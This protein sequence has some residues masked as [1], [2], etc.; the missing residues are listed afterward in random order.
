MAGTYTTSWQSVSNGEQT[1]HNP[2][3]LVGDE[4]IEIT[5][6]QVQWEGIETTTE[7]TDY[8][9]STNNN[10]DTATATTSTSSGS[11][12]NSTSTDSKYASTSF[13]DIPSGATFDSHDLRYAVINGSSNEKTVSID[14]S[15]VSGTQQNTS[16][17][18]S[19]S[20]TKYIGA[21]ST[22]SNYIGGTRAI[23]DVNSVN[24]ISVQVDYARTNYTETSTSSQTASTSY[25]SVPFGHSFHQ[26]RHR[27]WRGGAKEVD[28]TFYSNSVG[29]TESITSN[30]TNTEVKVKL[31]TTGRDSTTTTTTHYTKNPSIS[32]DV[33]ADSGLTLTD[34]EQSSWY[35]L[36]GLDSSSETFTHYI[37]DSGKARF[38]FTFDYKSTVPDAV[39]ETRVVINDTIYSIALAAPNDEGLEYSS[40]RTHL[41][42]DGVLAYDIVDPS[43]QYALPYFVY[44]PTHGK[45]ALRERQR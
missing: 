34:G 40:Y 37:D 38:R 28:D 27:E 21:F 7:E 22:T 39:A 9:Y 18:I 30:D 32:G 35:Q 20:S 43:N 12:S 26:H 29:D 8:T 2:K 3:S 24:G 10:S 14:Y 17:T 15:D 5:S 11:N 1:T 44:H 25:P 36:D 13:P 19:G 45:L 4:Y 33:S 23:N 41:P 31:A 16:L 6:A 42:N